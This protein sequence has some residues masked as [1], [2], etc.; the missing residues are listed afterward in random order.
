MKQAYLISQGLAEF[1]A[2]REQFGLLVSTL[3]SEA[4][5]QM[6]HAQLEEVI[7]Q[8]LSAVLKL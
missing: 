1:A 8:D 7:S 4:A 6:Q 2:A 5:L 3:Q